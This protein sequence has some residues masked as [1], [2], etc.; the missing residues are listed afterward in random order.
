MKREFISDSLHGSPP[1]TKRAILVKGLPFVR[2]YKYTRKHSSP[3]NTC[4]D[5]A[6][7]DPNPQVSKQSTQAVQITTKP[8]VAILRSDVVNP[9]TACW[10]KSVSSANIYSEIL[11]IEKSNL[12]M[13][14]D[15]L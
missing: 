15:P 10:C 1:Q 4:P 3:W 2:W 7:K 8:R 5:C 6:A 12:T 11:N 14:P 9:S 13:T